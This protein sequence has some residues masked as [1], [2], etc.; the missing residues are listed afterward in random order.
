M[1]KKV[2]I[3]NF[4]MEIGGVERSLLSLLE[5]IDYDKL[6]ISLHL[7]SHV[8]PL[9][10]LINSNVNLLE[11]KAVCNTFCLP[12]KQLINDRHFTLALK[13]LFAK[14]A[15]SWFKF[16]YSS[17]ES[18][19]YQLQK[20]WDYCVNNTEKLKEDFDV[21]ISYHWPHHYTAFKVT[22]KKKIA[23]IH[24]DYSNI[25]LDNEKDLRV[26]EAFDY[27]V[28]I[29][30]SCTVA[31]LSVYPSLKGKVILVENLT[32]PEYVKQMAEAP[33]EIELAQGFNL[34]SVGRLC[35]AKAFDKAVEVLGELNS[36]GYIDINWYIVGEGGDR[37]LI[38]SRIAKYQLEDRFNLV[39]STT[40]PYPYM[41]AADIYI[42]P[43]RYEGKAVT[44][45]EALI[46][47]KPVIITNY[48]TASSQI[49]NGVDGLICEQSIDGIADAIEHL[50]KNQISRNKYSSYNEKRDFNNSDQLDVLYNLLQVR[51]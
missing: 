44:V 17:T 27:I 10:T 39:G 45:G 42:Q 8:G 37:R 5:K 34:V 15:A 22:A 14:A 19:P 25:H 31:F 50:Y 29:S 28:S 3:T 51:I 30:D 41:N 9:M 16:R 46:L 26:W 1:K 4:N 40:N 11:E 47:A 13:R 6:L 12:I 32:N 2:L 7:H 18:G 33:L 43:S 38:E 48:T 20:I 49:T 21:A 36:R 24:T 35:N 23:W